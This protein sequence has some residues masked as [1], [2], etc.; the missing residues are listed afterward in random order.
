MLQ[1]IH[2]FLISTIKKMLTQSLQNVKNSAGKIEK[3]ANNIAHG[4]SLR[5]MPVDKVDIDF[6]NPLISAY[7]LGELTSQSALNVN[8]ARSIIQ[9]SGYRQRL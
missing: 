7:H 5:P 2:K 6:T 4:L 1:F 8:V 9:A 3:C